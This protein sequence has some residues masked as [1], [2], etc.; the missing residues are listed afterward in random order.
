MNATGITIEHNRKGAPTFARID[1]RKYGD[2]LKDFFTSEGVSV[3][4]L[5]YDPEFVAKIKK[6]EKQ[7]AKK[8]DLDKY[9]E[10]KAS[11]EYTDA[12]ILVYNSMI[13][14]ANIIA[15]NS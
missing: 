14:A 9:F 15:K 11:E 12:E 6:A 7:E 3:E 5:V 8:I 10:I 1:L 2:K 4:E 13:N